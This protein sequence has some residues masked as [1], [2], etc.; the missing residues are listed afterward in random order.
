MADSAEIATFINGE[1]HAV[2]LLSALSPEERQRILQ[3]IS[4]RSPQVA[5]ELSQKC[6]NFDALL[7]L[8]DIEL[9]QFS[10]VVTP[11]VLG[12]ALQ[13]ASSRFQREI[14]RKLQR[15]YAESCYNALSSTRRGNETV[16]RAQTRVLESVAFLLQNRQQ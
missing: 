16:K 7:D 3:Y 11:E 4:A 9:E 10:G 13:G 1:A 15:Q 14:L 8:E 12:I 5:R 6:F 2:E